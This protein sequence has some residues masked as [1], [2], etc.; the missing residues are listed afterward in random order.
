MPARFRFF[1]LLLAVVFSLQ[2]CSVGK[3]LVDKG[4]QPAHPGDRYAHERAKMERRVPGIT[5]WMDSLCASGAIRDTFIE[6]R[7]ARLHAFYAH[8]PK[9]SARTAVI[10]HGYGVNPTNI[11][12][13]ARVYRDAFG[14]NV[15]MPSMRHHGKS[16]GEAVQ[17][18]WLDR[19]DALKWSEVA[20]NAFSDTLQV[21]HGMSM[22]AASVMMAAGEALP[23]YVRGI[24]SDC[25]FSDFSE[26][27]R[28]SLKQY[29]GISRRSGRIISDA[30]SRCLERF[31]WDINDA[32]SV[33]QLAKCKVPVFFIH[34]TA[35]KLVP[36]KMALDNYAAKVNGVRELWLA[37]GSG[38]SR[39]YPDHPLE[40]AAR[41]RKFLIEH[42]E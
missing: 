23:D 4:L 7:G 9:L 27:L 21:F 38:H 30:R 2:G 12:M 41:L 29:L 28:H 6:Y 3:I 13:L 17:M 20:H 34:G 31:G 33:K 36:P 24:V 32:S 1:A 11:M 40:Y 42:V 16:G 26:E 10:C 19:L 15:L 22:G 18:G 35:D 25:G 37:P 8:S 39:S 5:H 14:Y